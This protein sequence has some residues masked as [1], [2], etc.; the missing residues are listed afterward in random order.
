MIF[1]SLTGIGDWNF[2]KGI[3][4][5]ATGANAIA[6]DIQT[7]LLSWKGDCF[8]SLNDFVDWLSRLDKG[9]EDNLNN[10]LQSVILSAYGVISINSFVGVLNRQTRQYTVTY[11]I[12]TIY[13]SSVQNTLNL[14]AG[15]PPGS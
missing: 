10:E 12:S 7:R 6:L 9:Q 1:R 14:S 11:N 2:G 8:F 15:L 3:Y 4:S 5:Y 13:S